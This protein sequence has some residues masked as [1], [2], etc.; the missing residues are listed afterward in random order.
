MQMA[1]RLPLHVERNYVKGKTY[2]SFRKGKGKRIRLPDDPTGAEFMEAYQAALTGQPLPDPREKVT[3]AA[4]GSIAA[5]IASYK[6]SDKY[7]RLRPTSKGQYDHRLETIRND[8]GHRSVS[9]LEPRRINNVILQPFANRPGSALD[10]LKKLR[11]L[12]RHAIRIG[13]LKQDPS[14]GLERPKIKEIRAWKDAELAA[15]EA[16]WPLGTKQRTA[17]ALQ[18]YLGTAR[19]DTHL[20]TWPQIEE[21]IATYERSKTGVPVYIGIA[22][23]LR[24][25]LAA[26]PRTHVTVINTAYGRPFTIDGYSRFMRDAITAAGLPLD[27]KP[28]GLRKALGRRLAD[29]GASAHNIMS[30][31]GHKTLAEADRYTRETDRRHGGRAAIQK[32]DRKENEITQTVPPSL[33]KGRKKK[34]KST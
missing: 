23:E 19:V 24:K 21:D 32:L 34:G 29:A 1:R 7:L 20:M 18:L 8:H 30:A 10:T 26:W 12:I 13:W 25:A 16:R 33:G 4:P 3:R 28:H 31:L 14:V 9:G 11:V 17:Y 15:F 5:L 22:D 2:L 6:Q 27:C